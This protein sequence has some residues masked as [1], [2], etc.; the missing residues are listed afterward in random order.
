MDYHKGT[1][2]S[3]GLKQNNINEKTIRDSI[4]ANV[5]NGS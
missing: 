5:N 4:I 3:G 2:C 1:K